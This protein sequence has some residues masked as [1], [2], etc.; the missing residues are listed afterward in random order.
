MQIGSI[1]GQPGKKVNGRLRVGYTT[2]RI[3]VEI[4]VTI[5]MGAKPGRTLVVS[6]GVHG[7]EVI[8]PLAV[9][10]VLRGLDPTAMTG[11]LIA[12]PLANMSSFEFLDRYSLWDKGNMQLIGK[13][14]GTLTQQLSHRMYQDVIAKGD[15]YI[16]I[17]SSS[18]EGF[19]WYGL[20]ESD[21]EG[22]APEVIATSREMA[23]A[24]GLEQIFGRNPWKETLSEQAI[25]DGI[26]AIAPETGGGGD[27]FQNGEQMVSACARGIVNVMKLMGIVPGEIETETNRAIIWDAH[28]EIFNNSEGGLVLRRVQRGQRVRKGELFAAKFDPTTGEEL[29]PILSPADGTVLNT[30]IV[31]PHCAPGRFVGILGDLMEEVDLTA[32]RWSFAMPQKSFLSP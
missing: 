3:P 12:V 21:V 27:F 16:E 25:A 10:E 26:P 5:V 32:R 14:D 22:A 1:V 8:G 19:V 11:A 28:T 18:S 13:A 2:G 9:G 15:A 4:P 30:G 20:Y 17:H 29:A 6:G 7:R 24:F 31:W 23:L